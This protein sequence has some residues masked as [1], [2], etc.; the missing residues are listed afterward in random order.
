M[1]RTSVAPP[2][3]RR[4]GGRLPAGRPATK[5]RDAM[6]A[7]SAGARRAHRADFG[8]AELES[9]RIETRQPMQMNLDGE[10]TRDTSFE[11]EV[12]PRRLPFILPAEAPL[13]KI[14]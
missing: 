12:L 4:L 1:S 14:E 3:L 11:F 8:H 2:R 7:R 10:P 6:S 5:R 13:V 9:F